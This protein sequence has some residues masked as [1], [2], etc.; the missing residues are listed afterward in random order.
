M[1]FSCIRRGPFTVLMYVM[2]RPDFDVNQVWHKGDSSIPCCPLDMA[3]S[4][5]QANALEAM[6]AREDCNPN[7][8]EG[9]PLISAIGW[10]PGVEMLLEHP[11]MNLTEPRIR[12]CF[13]NERASSVTVSG[14]LDSD[15]CRSEW[16]VGMIEWLA[17][18]FV[19]ST[20][21]IQSLLASH[22]KTR[23]CILEHFVDEGE[24]VQA[25]KAARYLGAA[26]SLS[27]KK[28][29]E[30]ESDLSPSLIKLVREEM[31]ELIA[32]VKTDL[33]VT[34]KPFP[35]EDDSEDDSDDDLLSADVSDQS[36]SE[37]NSSSEDEDKYCYVDGKRY[38][39]DDEDKYRWVNGKKYRLDEA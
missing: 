25:R 1:L 15:K 7:I 37:H 13:E 39:L 32:S 35:T 33:K 2:D 20:T 18:F 28:G 21:P 29:M 26:L 24:M 5:C 11:K 3:A 16:T 22:P 23:V 34:V 6:L 8:M 31:D 17:D 12:K 10:Q 14:I 27:I 36:E 30:I 38:K 9:S 19:S 4:A